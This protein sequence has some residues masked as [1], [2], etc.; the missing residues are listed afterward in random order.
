MIRSVVTTRD[1]VRIHYRRA[2][3]GPPL[4]LLHGYPQTGHMWRKVMPALAERFTVV[5]P[6]LR[7]Y[8]DSDRPPSGYDKRTMASDIAD[9]IRALGLGPVV[10]VGHDR[11][12]RVAHRFALDH[13]ALLTRLVLLDIAPT[14]DV[15]ASTDQASARVRWHWFFHQVPDLP[16]A[17]T[18]GREDVY[19]RYLYKAWAYNP[20][21]IEEEAVQ[22][23]LRCF[24]QAG[25]MRA[26]FDDYRAGAT[27]DLEHDGADRDRKIAV[28]TLVLWGES[29]RT[30]QA[31][32]MLGVWRARC[33]DP[34]EGSPV[35]DCGHFIP[36]EQPGAVVDA[37]VRFCGATP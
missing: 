27:L 22:E 35:A 29:A 15:F 5:A 6:D 4:V 20:A 8:G 26:A 24:R 21:A 14:Y 19:L 12:A 2:G 17:L 31:A 16:E 32:D 3:A 23:Y 1:R 34:I 30:A 10:L 11:G 33:A 18:A 7:G 37:I 28:P 13:S 36:E 9:L 25:A